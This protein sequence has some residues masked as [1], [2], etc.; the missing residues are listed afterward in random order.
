[1]KI[2][3]FFFSILLTVAVSVHFTSVTPIQLEAQGRTCCVSRT[4][5]SLCDYCASTDTK[6]N[7]NVPPSQGADF[8][9]CGGN[10]TPGF[11]QYNSSNQPICRVC[12]NNY[13]YALAC[14]LPP[15][16]PPPPPNPVC[17]GA[18]STTADCP[19]VGGNVRSVCMLV[20]NQT[21]PGV[22]DPAQ[23]VFRC[24]NPN[25]PENSE[26]G[27]QCFCRNA[28]SQCGDKCGNWP[29]GK[30]SFCSG[31]STCSWV[32]GPS[33]GG[34]GNTFC[35]PITP[36]NG[37]TRP[38][39]LIETSYRYLLRPN[40]SIGTTQT[41]V[42]AACS[43]CVPSLPGQATLL[44]PANNS[45]VFISTPTASVSTVFDL[46]STGWGV[47]CPVNNNTHQLRYSVNGG[48]QQI[49]L[50]GSVIPNLSVGDSVTWFV[51]K[52]NGGNLN[53]ISSTFRFIV[54]ASCVPV[55]PN[56]AV[57]SFPANNSQVGLL[58][59]SSV[60]V[61]YNT[62]N[63]W[64]VSCTGIQST[65]LQVSRGCTGSYVNNG[66]ANVISGLAVNDTVCWRVVKNNGSLATVSAEWRFTVRPNENPWIIGYNGDVSARGGIVSNVPAALTSITSPLLNRTNQ[67]LI[68]DQ[69]IA[70]N[71]TYGLIAGNSTLPVT[72]QSRTRQFTTNYNDLSLVPPIESTFTN[73]Y[74][75]SYNTVLTNLSSLGG[76]IVTRAGNQTIGSNTTTSAFLGVPAGS[77]NYFLITGTLSIGQNVTCDTRTI[78]FVNAGSVNPSV[79]ISPNFVNS[80]SNSAC[81]FITTGNILVNGGNI[82][83]PGIILSDPALSRYDVVEAA[84]I[85]NGNLETT[86]DSFLPTEKWDA[87]LIKGSVITRDL[88]LRRDVNADANQLQPSQ[89]FFY[90]PRYREI[91]KAE[92]ANTKYSLREV[93][94]TN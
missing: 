68:S 11:V 63:G 16:P 33:C 89:V 62:A 53:S 69:Q 48:P 65:A 39:C 40:G 5:P 94:F 61:G 35:Q 66:S 20:P 26:W 79:T 38:V 81:I 43:N 36:G 70:F 47:N 82:S 14:G 80:G 42:L 77:K 22:Y 23:M 4:G 85:T 41:D 15:A 55:A 25:C 21:S 34:L 58:P 52:N 91:F 72:K 74:D 76:S 56:P 30:F 29:D 46:N 13:P 17:G 88:V 31:D 37:Y 3:V 71:S 2:K 45:T 93:G 67:S 32:N 9:G 57:L 73:W 50:N 10:S 28:T 18:C 24:V 75:Y 49:I 1:M 6:T 92:F 84:L 64:G 59:G 90:D 12:P 78:F 87:L 60:N 27:T 51:V 83:N 44:I 19:I 8:F 54:A 7:R 86:R